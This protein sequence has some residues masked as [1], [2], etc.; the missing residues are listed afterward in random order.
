MPLSTI[1]QLYRD[2]QFYWWRKLEYPEKTT[3]LLQVTGKL[4]NLNI[5]NGSLTPIFFFSATFKKMLVQKRKEQL[6]AYEKQEKMLRE[7]KQSGKS[8]K[9][10]VCIIKYSLQINQVSFRLNNLGTL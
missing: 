4:F 7:M 10:A 5:I 9:Q 1:F 2:S 6:K 8:T 3:N